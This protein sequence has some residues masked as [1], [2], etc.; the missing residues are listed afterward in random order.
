[1]LSHQRIDVR[2]KETPI[3]LSKDQSHD[4]SAVALAIAQYLD[5]VGDLVIV[6]CFLADQEIKLDLRKITKP[7]VG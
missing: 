3:F 6:G 1:M 5:S 7:L 4:T 2:K